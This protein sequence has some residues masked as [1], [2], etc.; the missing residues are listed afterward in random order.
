MCRQWLDLST[1][2]K[3]ACIEPQGM[4]SDATAR[5]RGKNILKICSKTAC[6][7]SFSLRTFS[8][9]HPPFMSWPSHW[10]YAAFTLHGLLRTSSY[11]CTIQNN[12]CSIQEKNRTGIMTPKI[13]KN[14]PVVGPKLAPKIPEI[15]EPG[16]RQNHTTNTTTAIH[17][18]RKPSNWRDPATVNSGQAVL[19]SSWSQEGLKMAQDGPFPWL[20]NGGAP[21]SYKSNHAN[22][23]ASRAILELKTTKRH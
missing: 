6:L 20:S 3:R 10:N 4:P 16:L 11:P 15:G 23:D 5:K 13:T 17:S 22:K 19:Q 8:I 7:P 1:E 21:K 12:T 14:G 9:L 2:A 18:C